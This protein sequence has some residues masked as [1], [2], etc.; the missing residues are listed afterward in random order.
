MEIIKYDWRLA[1]RLQNGDFSEVNLPLWFESQKYSYI[2]KTVFGLGKNLNVDM[3]K[4]ISIYSQALYRLAKEGVY[5]KMNAE[6]WGGREGLIEVIKNSGMYPC[7]ISEWS[8]EKMIAYWD[9][10]VV[11]SCEHILR[12]IISVGLEFYEHCSS[13]IEPLSKHDS[14]LVRLAY[15]CNLD[16]C[17]FLNDPSPRVAKVARIRQQFE[18]KWQSLNDEDNEKQRIMF[19]TEAIKNEQITLM[20][21]AVAYINHDDWCYAFFGGPL[22][23]AEVSAFDEDILWYIQDRRILADK[24]N[25]LIK[26]GEIS[27]ND[28]MMPECFQERQR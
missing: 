10:R 21:G 6:G 24:L 13:I 14:E 25:E 26:K 9:E 3:L 4:Y 20:D 15:C 11:G 2:W 17:Q 27:F 28:G 16:Y 18:E 19:L 5:S 8:Y 7:N 1:E 23:R 12:L 22:F